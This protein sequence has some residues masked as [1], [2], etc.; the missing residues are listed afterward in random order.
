MSN[1]ITKT[2]DSMN[3]L[4]EIDNVHTMVKKLMNTKHF[5]KMGEDGI[6]AIIMTAKSIGMPAIDALQ[7]QLYYV[8]GKVGMSYEAMNMYIRNAGH[9]VQIKH[10]D[11]KSCTL[12]G[13]R[14][15][16]GD[17]A[18]ITFDMDDAKKAGKNYDKHPKTMLFARCLS[19][20]KRFL[21]PDVCTK[22]YVK[23]EMDDM[24]DD[25]F[26]GVTLDSDLP[27]PQ[28]I[29]NNPPEILKEVV[30]AEQSDELKSIFNECSKDTQKL[31]M[32][33]LNGPAINVQSLDDLP[34][35]QFAKIKKILMKKKDEVQD[36]PANKD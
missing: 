1:E 25:H 18:E 3:F 16:N 17:T 8:Q 11:T 5:Q 2:D 21:F 13:K 24:K 6:F 19:M 35:D 9:S 4:S 20:L 15:D 28:E 14:K 27:T 29:L 26:D 10:L 34:K 30:S 36:A 23:E 7:G 22:V 12:I 31:F 33:F 32:E